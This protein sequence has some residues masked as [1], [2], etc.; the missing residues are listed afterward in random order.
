MGRRAQPW[1]V[2]LVNGAAAVAL[3]AGVGLRLW[4]A[5]LPPAVLQQEAVLIGLGTVLA[6][7]GVWVRTSSHAGKIGAQLGITIAAAVLCALV[8]G[9]AG[10]WLGDDLPPLAAVVFAVVLLQFDAAGE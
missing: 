2:P 1:N 5:N 10:K 4:Q 7:I 8:L 9:V 6:G 3:I